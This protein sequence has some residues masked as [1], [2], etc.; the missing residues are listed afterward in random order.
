[1]R[2][3]VLSGGSA[4]IPADWRHRL[5]EVRKSPILLLQLVAELQAE[6]L[7]PKDRQILEDAAKTG[8]MQLLEVLA[9]LLDLQYDAGDT[10]VTAAAV[11]GQWAAVEF[12]LGIRETIEIEHKK[13][14]SIESRSNVLPARVLKFGPAIEAAASARMEAP[15]RALLAA[16]GRPSTA[17][18]C[19]AEEKQWWV[20][21]PALVSTGIH[22]ELGGSL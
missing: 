9:Q 20:V 14:G 3:G 7:P 22:A 4:A 2:F 21:M 11:A 10:A 15:L 8:N 18:F 5:D 17:A 16:G 13:G 1:M 6:D 12:L 19:A